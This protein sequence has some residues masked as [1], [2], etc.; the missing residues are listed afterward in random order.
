MAIRANA[1]GEGFSRTSP[2]LPHTIM[3][4]IML[5]TDRDDYTGFWNYNNGSEYSLGTDQ[6]GTTLMHSDVVGTENTGTNL[7]LNT[8]YHVAVVAAG[9]AGSLRRVY[10]NGILD[11]TF[12]TDDPTA[13]TLYFMNVESGSDFLDGRMANAIISTGNWTQDEIQRQML[14][15]APVRVNDLYGWYP[16]LDV[17]TGA[18]D[19][20]ANGNN[21]TAN[22]T[23]TTEDGP[24]I[25][26][27]AGYQGYLLRDLWAA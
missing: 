6:T 27:D 1:T 23:L 10:L 14:Q 2:T 4:W 16:M 18:N 11:I 3:A 5:I 20:S 9:G 24:P 12:S 19:F 21:L 8:W 22:G 17:G 13:G 25:P 15:Y 7:A 26:W